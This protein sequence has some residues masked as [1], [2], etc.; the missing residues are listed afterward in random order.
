MITKVKLKLKN[1]SYEIIKGTDFAVKDDRESHLVYE[2][3]GVWYAESNSDITRGNIA[4]IM[5]PENRLRTFSIYGADISLKCDFVNS[6]SIYFELKSSAC[7]FNNINGGKMGISNSK[8]DN[9]F[10]VSSFESLKIDCGY[11]NVSV[12]LPKTSE[13]YDIT[14]K[15][16]IG[17]VILNSNLLPREYRRES[18]GKKID[19][20]CGMGE[21]RINTYKK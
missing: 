6:D 3:N 15:H 1:G 7:E 16:G 11:G 9:R 18:A 8:G 14:S 12:E 2:E 21:V 10:S 5:L 17:E 4:T 19:I 20:V 13:G